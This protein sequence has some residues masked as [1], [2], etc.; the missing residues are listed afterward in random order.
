MTW[1]QTAC[2]SPTR[3]AGAYDREK[4][5]LTCFCQL[6]NELSEKDCVTHF[7]ILTFMLSNNY[8]IQTKYIR[9]SNNWGYKFLH[10]SILFTRRLSFI[11]ILEV[12]CSVLLWCLYMCHFATVTVN[13]Y[14]LS[15]AFSIFLLSLTIASSF[16]FFFFL[17]LQG[18]SDFAKLQ[19]AKSDFIGYINHQ[20]QK[21]YP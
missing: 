12:C 6:D 17:F 1:L 13:F 15:F 4:S 2:T 7:I 5:M 9:Y 10:K 20:W 11:P 18:A 19:L 21:I 16:S 14:M 3:F 8:L